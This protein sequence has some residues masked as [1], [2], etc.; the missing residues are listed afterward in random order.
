MS[1]LFEI[2]LPKVATAIGSLLHEVLPPSREEM[3]QR[4]LNEANDLYDLE[5]RMREL[6]RMAANGSLS[7]ARSSGDHLVH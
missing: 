5:Y 2:V 1:F 3:E 7:A 6:D 4:Y